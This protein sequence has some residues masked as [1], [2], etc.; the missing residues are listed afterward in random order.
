MPNKKR[1]ITVKLTKEYKYP[2]AMLGLVA[3][4]EDIA[5]QTAI[6]DMST[7]V[8]ERHG[9]IQE[10]FFDEISIKDNSISFRNEPPILFRNNTLTDIC[11]G[12][13]KHLLEKKYGAFNI[14]VNPGIYEIQEAEYDE[15]E[16]GEEIVIREE[17]HYLKANIED[18]WYSLQREFSHVIQPIM[19]P[20]EQERPRAYQPK[21]GAIYG[22]AFD[23]NPVFY[24]S[25]LETEI[26][27]DPLEPG[28]KR[29]SIDEL[30]EAMEQAIAKPKA[31]S[32]IKSKKPQR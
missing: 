21:Y 20:Q 9:E 19:F 7:D 17:A 30:R 32:Y 13:S 1:T 2:V 12:L 14:E 31:S 23:T 22:N 5:K 26:S 29:S 24:T 4:V 11:R 27:L 15:D 25:G 3:N 18:E 28:K 6:R 8:Q 16:F 10:G